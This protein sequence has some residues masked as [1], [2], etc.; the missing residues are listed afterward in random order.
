[1]MA[2]HGTPVGGTRRDAARF[3]SGRHALV[4]Y[5]NPDDMPMVAEA[6]ASFVLDNGSYTFW[7][8]GKAPDWDGYLKWAQSW[9]RH[10]G[11]DWALIPDAIDGSEDENWRL[12][13]HYGRKIVLGVPVYHL[14]ESL[15]H[16]ERLVANYPRV[17]LGSSGV[18]KTPGSEAWWGR[19]GEVMEVACDREGVPRAKLHGLRCLDPQ[20]FSRLPL[21]SADSCSAALNSAGLS[22]FGMYPHPERWGRAE[23]LAARIEHHNSAA[24]WCAPQPKLDFEL[25]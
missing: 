8:G 20:I 19:M 23:V 13:F 7:Q 1:M 22:R 9:S 4:S 11:Y 15:A 25:G 5:A 6:C 12:M 24:V 16:L 10:P 21:S 3:L 14:H 2:Y 18:W 17:A